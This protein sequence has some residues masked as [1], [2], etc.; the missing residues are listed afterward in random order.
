MRRFFAIG[1]L[2]FMGTATLIAGFG[3]QGVSLVG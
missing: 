1:F 3:V 2:S